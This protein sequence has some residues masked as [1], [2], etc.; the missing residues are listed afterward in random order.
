MDYDSEWVFAERSVLRGLQEIEMRSIHAI[1]L[2]RYRF[3]LSQRLWCWGVVDNH[4]LVCVG[5]WCFVCFVCICSSGGF[6]VERNWAA[7]LLSSTVKLYPFLSPSILLHPSFAAC[8][9]LLNKKSDSAKVR[10]SLLSAPVCPAFLRS[11]LSFPA[12]LRRGS[13]STFSIQKCL[14]L[15]F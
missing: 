9:S 5:I 13:S 8:K 6:L 1:L 12:S 2:H 10:P 14:F 15:S 11:S 3:A 7:R 4:K